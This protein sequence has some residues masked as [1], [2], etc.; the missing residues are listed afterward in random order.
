MMFRSEI[1]P[2]WRYARKCEA[3][4]G[5]DVA[6][7]QTSDRSLSPVWICALALARQNMPIAAKIAATGKKLPTSEAVNEYIIK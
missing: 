5:V 4:F 7:W 6:P 2:I 3:V 1:I